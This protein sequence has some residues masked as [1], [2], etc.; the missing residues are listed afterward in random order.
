MIDPFFDLDRRNVRSYVRS[1]EAEL[2]IGDRV[3]L[4]PKG[5][6]DILDLALDGE[7]AEV[8]SIEEDYEGNIHVAVVLENDP[9]KDLGGLRQP[10]HRFFF[11]IAELEPVE[12]KKFQG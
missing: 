9:G 7:I 1:G 4:R 11:R 12:A 10:G 3:R 8:E 5:R 2:R 6:S